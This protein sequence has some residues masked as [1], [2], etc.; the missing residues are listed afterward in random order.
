MLSKIHLIVGGARSGKSAYAEQLAKDISSKVLYLATAV[1]TDED[2]A[3][4][5]KRHQESRPAHWKTI[6][7][8]KSFERLEKDDKFTSADVVLLD[9]L[10]IL[11]TN[12]M[13]DVPLDYDTATP[14]EIEQV[15]ESIWRELR[16][17]MEIIRKWNKT[18]I[19]VT[20]EV[21]MGL[22]PAYRLGNHFRDISGR[23]NRRVAE[24]ADEVVFVAVGIPLKLKGGQN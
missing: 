8:Y 7:M 6:E 10:T 13:F 3:N 19:L 15:E 4:R 22:V 2:M 5:I 24:Q 1:V 16:S 23:M 11:M 20:N 17:L 9:C 12:N 21:G 18:L 14:Y